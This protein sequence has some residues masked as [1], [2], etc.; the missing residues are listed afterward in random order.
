M[1]Q[2][3]AAVPNSASTTWQPFSSQTKPS[4]TIKRALQTDYLSKANVI[5]KTARP[6]EQNFLLHPAIIALFR[7]QLPSLLQTFHCSPASNLVFPSFE[8]T[9]ASPG[10][11]NPRPACC[12][13]L[14]AKLP[15]HNY[16]GSLILNILAQTSR[17]PGITFMFY[18][19]VNCGGC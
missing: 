9:L 10:G 17:T 1:S 8:N 11:V 16:T 5:L 12:C 7:L 19:N 3:T 13:F 18:I 4:S 6:P 14:R 15:L 2:F